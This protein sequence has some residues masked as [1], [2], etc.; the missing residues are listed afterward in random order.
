MK[1]CLAQLQQEREQR[2]HVDIVA[3][4]RATVNAT[5]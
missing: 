4:V 2:R 3:S 5:I 1:G